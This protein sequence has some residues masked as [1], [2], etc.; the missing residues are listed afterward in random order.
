MEVRIIEA[1]VVAT[2]ELREGGLT[3]S[4]KILGVGGTE[5]HQTGLRT[6]NTCLKSEE[7]A[8]SIEV[9]RVACRIQAQVAD[10]PRRRELANLFAIIGGRPEIRRY[11]DLSG[12][13]K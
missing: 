6:R 8:A 2:P 13:I 12:L 3:Q 1:R 4:A 11:S 10:S 7:L 9:G 5:A